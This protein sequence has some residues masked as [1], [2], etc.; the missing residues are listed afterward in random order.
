MKAAVLHAPY[1]LRL[2]E[3][4]VPQAGADGLVLRIHNC[5]VCGTDTQMYVGA[6]HPHLPTIMGHEAAGEVVEVGSQLNGYQVGERLTFWC[7]F[8]CFAEYTRI[9]PADLAVGR[10]PDN[11]TWEQG[12]NTQLLCACL[13][14][15]D[16]AQ[17]QSGQRALVM[18]QGPVGLLVMQGAKA[19]GAQVIGVDL[20]DLRVDMARRL[21]ADMAIKAREP[22][23]PERI[24]QEL[25]EVDVV[26]DCMN[27]DLS[28]GK[29]GLRDAFRVLREG[30][31]C[32]MLSLGEDPRGPAPQTIVHRLI[33]MQPSYVP[34]ERS[35]QLMQIACELVADGRVDVHTFVTH[36]MELDQVE[37]ALRLSRERPDEVVKIMLRI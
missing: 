18:G 31:R 28:Q 34:M 13:R 26:F 27:E 8:G 2:E 17:L 7:H 11:V 5:A 6:T 12:A 16:T 32:V 22:D 24:R 14:G 3:R 9:V 10:L 25:G 36:R 23:W 21:G 37:E 29:T 1:D 30:G 19:T 20:Y 4:D 33:S 15:V 35:R